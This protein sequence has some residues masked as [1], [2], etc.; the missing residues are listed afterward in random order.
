MFSFNKGNILIVSILFILIGIFL[1]IYQLNFENYWLD[2]MTSFW[3]ADPS[4]SLKD[5]FI[6]SNHF[7]TPPIFDLF[8]KK[9]LEFFS[10]DPEIGR[11]VPLFFGILSIPYLGILSFQ[12][13]KTI[14]FYYLSF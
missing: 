8:L 2:E 6:R 13:S 7:H 14:L 12:V 1:R 4:L 5:T 3:A 11:H 9:Y 10:Y